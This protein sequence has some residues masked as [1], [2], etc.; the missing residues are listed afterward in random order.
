MTDQTGI[1]GTNIFEIMVPLKY[2]TNFWGTLEIP[3]ITCEINLILTRSAYCVIV[4]AEVANQNATCEITD[5]KLHVPVV[6]VST[7]D[8]SKLLQNL[9][10]GFKRR[11]SW[12]K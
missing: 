1:N 11:I 9:E 6:T 2:L 5:T 8:N 7:Q 3:L 12:N 4:S 10:S